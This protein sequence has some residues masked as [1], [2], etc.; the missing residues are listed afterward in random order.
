MAQYAGDDAAYLFHCSLGCEVVQ[1]DLLSSAQEAVHEINRQ[2]E[3]VE[4]CD[5]FKA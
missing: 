5:V 4:P 1:D 3:G 2:Y